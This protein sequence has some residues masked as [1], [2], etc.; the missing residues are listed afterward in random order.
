MDRV[1]IE[2]WDKMDNLQKYI[3]EAL[4]K[5]LNKVMDVQKFLDN[6]FMKEI[7]II[8]LNNQKMLK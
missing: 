1:F 5:V 4:L 2:E 8:I 7:L 6:L 3:K